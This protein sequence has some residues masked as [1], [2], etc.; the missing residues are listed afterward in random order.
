[1]RTPRPH[2]IALLLLLPR[3]AQGKTILDDTALIDQ[4]EQSKQ[5]SSEIRRRMAQAAM[6]EAKI[7]R[8]RQKYDGLARHAATLYFAAADMARVDAMYQV[9]SHI[10]EGS[11]LLHDI[12]AL[13]A[14]RS[15]MPLNVTG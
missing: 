6:N 12:P 15:H 7:D 14:L 13:A 8:A 9:W 11:L 4:L 5:T 1:L 2:S 3:C 10:P